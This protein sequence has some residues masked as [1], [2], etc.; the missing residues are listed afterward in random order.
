MVF[1]NPSAAIQECH[2]MLRPGGVL[3]VSTWQKIGWLPDIRAAFATTTDL[4]P[5]PSDD[6]VMKASSSDGHWDDAKWVEK[7][8]ADHGFDDVN[9]QVVPRQ[10][11]L[12]NVDEF[13]MLLPGTVGLIINKFW[14]AEEKQK[15]TTVCNETVKKYM[16]GKYGSGAVVWDWVAILA[17][18]RK[19]TR[20]IG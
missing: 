11:R 2:R 12:E 10:S 16:R 3:G 13:M 18:A 5:F 14:T 4:P 6:R 19:L 20:R 8:L 9:V 17:T 1:P 7:N 15:C